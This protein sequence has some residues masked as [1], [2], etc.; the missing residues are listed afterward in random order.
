MSSL[1]NSHLVTYR[2]I[3]F[4]LIATPF[5]AV[6]NVLVTMA[7]RNPRVLAVERLNALPE[8]YF[9]A[10]GTTRADAIRREFA[11]YY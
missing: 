4:E 8:E 3:A 5:R 11:I 1:P 9:T 10:R 2:E 7:A 6:F